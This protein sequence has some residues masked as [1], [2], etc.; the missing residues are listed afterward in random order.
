MILFPEI[1]LE[2]ENNIAEIFAFELMEQQYHPRE[3]GSGLLVYK[4][5]GRDVK[6]IYDGRD[7]LL[8]AYISPKHLHYP[9]DQW[10]EIYME[11][12]KKFLQEAVL[13]IAENTND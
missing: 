3:F 11:R 13:K 6:L 7:D 5:K 4:I 10:Q 1:Q 9:H 8:T 12:P 2:F